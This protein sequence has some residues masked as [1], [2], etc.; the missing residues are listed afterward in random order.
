MARPSWIGYKLGG[1]YEIEELLG[2]GGMAAVYRA[3][4]PNL[5]RVVAVKL[6][7]PHLSKE[8][9]FVR[10]FEAEAAAV[11]QLRHPHII[12]VFDFAQD[13]DVFYIVF[14][15]LAGE[16]LQDYLARLEAAN[17]RMTFKQAVKIG[18]D[19]AGALDYAHGRGLVHRDVKPANIMLNFD[20]DAILMDF[21]IVK[22]TGGPQH[23]ATGAILGTARYMAPEQIRGRPSDHR[24]DIYAV[25]IMLFQMVAGQ[26]PYQADS[27][28]TLMMMQVN[29]PVPDLRELRADVPADL[30]RIIYKATEKDPAD[31]YQSAAELLDDLS[32]AKL[33]AVTRVDTP[34]VGGRPRPATPPT[35][36]PRA[37]TP[38][39][40]P[41]R[42]PQPMRNAGTSSERARRAPIPAP[43]GAKP[44]PAKAAANDA[45]GVLR[46]RRTP[47]IAGCLALLLIALCAGAA[48]AILGTSLGDSLLGRTPEAVLADGETATATSA[49]AT[50]TST[51]TSAEETPT[52]AAAT[53][54]ATE[55]VV[56]P[57]LRPT[58]SPT[59]APTQTPTSA[60]TLAPSPTTATGPTVRID[61]ISLSGDRYIVDYGTTGYT[62]A[63]PGMH[64]HFFFDTVPPDQ[65]G[66]PA[67][68]PWYVWGGPR[69][70]D[71]YGPGDRPGG[72]TQM[73]ALVANTDHSIILGTGNCVNLP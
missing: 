24:T 73:C 15:F 17:R 3:T 9:S 60:P 6:I 30:A 11:A 1:R 41:Q 64:V 46:G 38:A 67:N 40:R 58:N 4:D 25:G 50:A 20:G 44:E 42:S 12:Q 34:P 56:E 31:R 72:A 53:P 19:L 71:G 2:E 29:E 61:N 48:Y 55:E 62:E 8:Q 27:A 35:P 22:I 70:F 69:P 45:G 33:E 39:A 65:A 66:L 37:R 47:L 7:H 18:S 43:P 16:T 5:K 36:R 52:T 28:M 26:A 54:T 32:K 21:G 68:G 14:E 10:R 13:E 63:L 23:T 51:Q 59:A 57:T 49:Q